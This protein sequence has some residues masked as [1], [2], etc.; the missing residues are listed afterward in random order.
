MEERMEA[1]KIQMCWRTQMIASGQMLAAVPLV[2]Q[3]VTH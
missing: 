1:S 3:D 2:Q